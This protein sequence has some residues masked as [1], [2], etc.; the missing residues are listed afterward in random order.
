MPWPEDQDIEVA[1]R[2][3]GEAGFGQVDVLDSSRPQNCIYVCSA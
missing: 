1:R 2:M 3:L